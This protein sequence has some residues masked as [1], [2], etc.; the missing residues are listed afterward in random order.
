[1]QKALLVLLVTLGLLAGSAALS[2]GQAHAAVRA[3]A[4]I[5]ATLGDRVLNAAETRAGDWYSYGAAGPSTFDCSG[6]AVWAAGRLGLSLPRTTYLMV[7]S[8]HL[9]RVYS[10]R[11]GDLAFWGP[12][13]AP[14]HVEIVTVWYHTTFGAQQTGTRVGYHHYYPGY[15]PSAFYRLR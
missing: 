15:A 4:L 6:L 14:Y 8:W 7:H 2:S 5:T 3:P 11:R 13:G 10:P 9:Y 1:L 12:V